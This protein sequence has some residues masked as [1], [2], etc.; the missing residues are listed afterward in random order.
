VEER[1]SGVTLAELLAAFSLATDL[2]LG[3]PMEHLL[4]SWQIASRL[5][6]LAGLPDDEQPTLFHVAMLSW[7][8][9]VADA[10]EV[11]ANFGDD[12]VFRAD[13]Y[14][15]DLGGLSGMAFFMARAGRGQRLPR[16]VRAVATL[17]A[18]GG[19]PVLRGI[20]GHCLVTSTLANQLGLPQQ[21]STAVRQFFARWDGRGVPRGLHGEE[22]SLVV[23][24][25]HL[26]DIVE[27]H[28]R[29]GGTPA[30]VRVARKRSGRQFDP[31]LV[32]TFCAHAREVLPADTDEHDAYH[33]FARQPGLRA[34]LDHQQLDAALEA[35]ADFTDLRCPTRAGHSRGVAVLAA[36][37]ARLLRLPARDVTTLYRAALV[38]DIGL[39]GVPA[40]ILNKSGPLTAHEQERLRAASYFTERVLAR[41]AALARL[42]QIAGMAHERMDGSGF[43][44][45]IGGQAIPLPARI[46]AAAC[47][48]HELLEPRSSRA[49]YP[50]KEAAGMIRADIAAGRFDQPAADA[51]LAAA[52]AGTRR[53]VGGPAGLTPRELEVLGLI[54]RGAATADIA[55]Q[56]GI[57]PKTAGTH[58][59]RIYAKSGASNRSTATLFALRNGLLGALDDG[60]GTPVTS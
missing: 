2:G 51:V 21:T 43:H 33:L 10:P 37:A 38:H 16:R 40:T 32:E 59:E 27:V 44:R 3:Q 9:C 54:A 53:R 50:L 31:G 11:T 55:A 26:A 8:G 42:G 18:T 57:S 41:P 30:A 1:D 6:C 58:I 39:H 49:P 52:G 34:R 25:F 35:L 60:P 56:L 4:R 24:L 5:G 23:R 28:H 12:I 29:H 15:T 14:Q 48:L 13:S 36:A 19:A 20:Q 47:A 46:L 7:V 45:G 17:A 22:I